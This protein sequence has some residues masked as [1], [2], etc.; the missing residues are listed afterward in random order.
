VTVPVFHWEY[1]S[2]IFANPRLTVFSFSGRSFSSSLKYRQACQSI[3]VAHELQYIQHHHYLLQPS[4][5]QQNFVQVSRD[6]SDLPTVI[7]ELL[8]NPDK[9][10]A[11]AENNV[12]TFRERYLTPAA[13][14]CY[15]RILFSGYAGV[16]NSPEEGDTT[17]NWG[18]EGR[19]MRYESFVLL[20]SRETMKFKYA[21]YIAY[22]GL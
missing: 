8:A 13:E 22:S 15:W 21:D 1:L 19:A 16:L 3:I 14:A 5:P 17:N 20:P 2:S 11:I 18:L 9:A 6:F 12:K 7:E 10:R 4:G